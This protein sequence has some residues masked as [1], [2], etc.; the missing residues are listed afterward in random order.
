MRILFHY[1]SG[2]PHQNCQPMIRIFSG[3]RTTP[4]RFNM[5]EICIKK[6]GC[7]LFTHEIDSSLFDAKKFDIK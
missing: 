5:D 2:L 4:S 6:S 3:Q 7:I 1:K